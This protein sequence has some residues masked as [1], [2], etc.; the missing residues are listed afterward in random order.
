MIPAKAVRRECSDGFEA[1]IFQALGGELR[2]IDPWTRIDFGALHAGAAAEQTSVGYCGLGMPYR[3]AG[4]TIGT[5]DAALGCPPFIIEILSDR[6]SAQAVWNGSTSAGR[7]LRRAELAALSRWS[8]GSLSKGLRVQQ[9]GDADRGLHAEL[10]IGD[11]TPTD[12]LREF[13][14]AFSWD[15]AALHAFAADG[16]LLTTEEWVTRAAVS[17]SRSTPRI[18]LRPTPAANW[19][20]VESPRGL[21]CSLQ[22]SGGLAES[23]NVLYLMRPADGVLEPITTLPGHRHEWDYARFT[24]VWLAQDQQSCVARTLLC[25]GFV[26]SS[27]GSWRALDAEAITAVSLLGDDG[28]L[29]GS[30][31]GVVQVLNGSQTLG[32]EQSLGR[33]R[34]RFA[35]LVTVAD[36]AIGVVGSQLLSA[37]VDW[38]RS[39]SGAPR[40]EWSLPLA[41]ML[42]TAR[43]CELDVDRWSVPTTLAVLGDDALLLIDPLRGAVRARRETVDATHAVWVGPHQLLLVSAADDAEVS[44]LQLL[45]TVEMRC[46][47]GLLCPLVS[48][49]ALRGDEIH[50]GFAQQTVAVWP[51]RSLVA[52]L[53]ALR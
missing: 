49:I 6:V 44:T 19:P 35:K 15:V 41:S 30:H 1:T 12:M 14:T 48:R 25:T 24:D 5:D 36:R 32:P 21:F 31:D 26:N 46:S 39:I 29:L 16:T 3:V 45:D 51:R 8:A 34:G 42:Q 2:A 7:A 17:I 50:V 38:A 23:D 47:R 28:F 40:A 4:V 37:R 18:P 9:Y 10:H 13:V 20:S 53:A 33:A 52:A 43:T 27:A 22:P 11:G